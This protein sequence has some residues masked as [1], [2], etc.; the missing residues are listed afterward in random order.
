MSPLST[1]EWTEVT[2]NPVTGCTKISDGCRVCY[3]ERMAKRLRA[4]GLDKYKK[5]FAVAM[6]EFVLNEPLRWRRFEACVHQLHV[7]SVSRVG[8]VVVH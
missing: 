6:H 2:W 3:A 7:R 4:M 5:G 1:I 8:P